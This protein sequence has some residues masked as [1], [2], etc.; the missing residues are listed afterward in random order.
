MLG[1]RSFDVSSTAVVEVEQP[2]GQAA[3]KLPMLVC[4]LCAFHV[5]ERGDRRHGAPHP[6]SGQLHFRMLVGVKKAGSVIGKVRAV[7]PACL[8]CQ[9]GGF[10][11]CHM[12][13]L[14]C[15][16]RNLSQ[17]AVL[18]VLNYRR[19]LRAAGRGLHPADTQDDWSQSR[20]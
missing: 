19:R 12:H 18:C 15:P 6:D 1:K 5:Q 2:P 17:L 16:V 20:C 11:L 13:C 9:H 10:W 8:P 14:C 3:D 4:V 7:S